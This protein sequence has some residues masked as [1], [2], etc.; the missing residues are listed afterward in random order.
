MCISR[1]LRCHLRDDILLPHTVTD[2][3]LSR[4]AIALA[5]ILVAKIQQSLRRR[6]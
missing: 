1:L 5:A 3:T 6:M 4:M 2:V